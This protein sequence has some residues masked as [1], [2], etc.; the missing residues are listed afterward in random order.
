MGTVEDF[1][2]V[3]CGH[4]FTASGDFNYGRLGEVYTPVVCPDHGLNSASVGINLAKGERLPGEP[5][6][7]YPCP[8]CRVLAP[9]W[10]RKSCP[11]CGGGHF[12]VSAIFM[13]D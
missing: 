5:E 7:A 8:V 9:R 2:C 13:S 10:D 4:E 6:L 1:R 12:E 11:R 3:D